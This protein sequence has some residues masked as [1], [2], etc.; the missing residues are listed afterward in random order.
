M[1]ANSYP[2]QFSAGYKSIKILLPFVSQI[3]FES[4]FCVESTNMEAWGNYPMAI[5]AGCD[6][7]FLLS[8]INLF[9]PID[10]ALK[11]S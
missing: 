8:L 10:Y 4:R 2:V 5:F 3:T 1:V 9:F 11:K 6:L 7:I